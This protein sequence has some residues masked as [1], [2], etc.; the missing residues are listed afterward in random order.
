MMVVSRERR[1]AV[2]EPML[3]LNDAWEGKSLELGMDK[4]RSKVDNDNHFFLEVAT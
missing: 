1:E 2:G 3:S 4:G